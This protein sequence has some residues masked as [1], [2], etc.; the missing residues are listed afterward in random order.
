RPDDEVP[1]RS[2]GAVKTLIRSTQDFLETPSIGGPARDTAADRQRRIVGSKPQRRNFGPEGFGAADGKLN[3]HAGKCDDEL[4]ASVTR[5][6]VGGPDGLAKLLGDAL[7]RTVPF[8]VSVL[9]VVTLELVDVEDGDA[10]VRPCDVGALQ[11]LLDPLVE[12]APL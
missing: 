6:Q 4:L 10:E 9:I 8:Q 11:L 1:A 7:Q 3:V 5:H 12:R 2:F